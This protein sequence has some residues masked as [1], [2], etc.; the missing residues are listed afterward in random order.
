MVCCSTKSNTIT[1][2]VIPTNRMFFVFPYFRQENDVTYLAPKFCFCLIT[3][4][5]G[6]IHYMDFKTEEK[7]QIYLLKV[8]KFLKFEFL[9]KMAENSNFKTL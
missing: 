5:H 1:H 2:I 4:I 7:I 6:L 9:T 3:Y 8:I